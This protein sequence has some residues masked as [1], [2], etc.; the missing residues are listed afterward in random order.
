M[1][2]AA[3]AFHREHMVI[4][5][6]REICEARQHTANSNRVICVFCVPREL[7]QQLHC[8]LLLGSWDGAS[9]ASRLCSGQQGCELVSCKPTRFQ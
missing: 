9:A 8:K 5:L 2:A 7:E 3:L 4:G 6:K 1:A